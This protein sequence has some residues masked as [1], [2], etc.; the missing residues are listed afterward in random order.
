M[1]SLC[2]KLGLG[3]PVW[4]DSTRQKEV[5]GMSSKCAA[6]INCM[7]GRVQMPVIEY[8]KR[9]LLRFL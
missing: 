1:Q 2:Q 8:M 4:T 3:G 7:D 5:N 9:S 6:A